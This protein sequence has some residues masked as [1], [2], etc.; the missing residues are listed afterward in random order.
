MVIFTIVG[1]GIGSFMITVECMN[2]QYIRVTD[3]LA[4]PL[5]VGF[6][7]VFDMLRKSSEEKG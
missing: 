3:F 7:L 5:F 2:P 1:V 6:G 4:V